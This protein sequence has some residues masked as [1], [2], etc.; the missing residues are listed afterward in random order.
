MSAC[1]STASG[2][3][4]RGRRG[5]E[6][7]VPVQP[8][9]D[10]ASTVERL[11]ALVRSQGYE[12]GERLG[13][14]RSLSDALGVSR[15]QLRRALDVMERT[16]EIVRKI[17]RGGG[18]VVSDGRIERNVNAV[19]SLPTIAR[20]QGMLVSSHVLSAVLTT[21]SPADARQLH[22]GSESL[23]YRIVRQRICDGSPL[24][25]EVNVLPAGMFPGLLSRDLTLPLYHIFEYDYDVVLE[26]VEETIEAIAADGELTGRLELAAGEPVMRIRRLSFGPGG[27]P[28]EKADEFYPASKIRFT[29]QHSGYVR[30]SATQHET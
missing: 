18:V 29:M 2:G 26:W 14:E 20:R 5:G 16:H 3:H 25:V 24:S 8:D 13:S 1:V 22:L 10:V 9:G 7:V 4:A 15:S 12:V 28:C 19:E 27:M 23:V 30:L 6:G 17:G 21:A 11:R